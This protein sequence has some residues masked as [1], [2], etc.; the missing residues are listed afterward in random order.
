M[1][2]LNSSGDTTS[3]HVKVQDPKASDLL[4]LSPDSSP[5]PQA[6]PEVVHAVVEPFANSFKQERNAVVEPFENSFKRHISIQVA[7]KDEV[8]ETVETPAMTPLPKDQFI[9][10][11]DKQ[12]LNPESNKFDPEVLKTTFPKDV[13]PDKKEE[14]ITEKQFKDIFSMDIEDFRKLKPWK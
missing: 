9:E 5:N 3:S 13:Q 12:Y 6:K 14:Y 1:V 10:V 8:C 11:N 4:L 7:Q 2:P